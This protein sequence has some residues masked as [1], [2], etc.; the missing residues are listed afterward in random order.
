[1]IHYAPYNIIV[2]YEGVST[3][4][5]GKRLIVNRDGGPSLP[6]AQTYEERVRVI[7]NAIGRTKIGK[8]LLAS[9]YG[10]VPVYIIPYK[11]DTCNARTG[12]V[13]SNSMLGI[14]VQYS[15]EMW[16]VD[17]C[18]HYPGYR[19]VETLFHEMVHASRFTNYG[20]SG[21]NLDPLDRMQDHEEFLAVMITDMFRE[22]EGAHK[23]NRD[24]QT[25]EL[26]S[27]DAL[28]RFLS[29]NSHYLDAIEYFLG[30]VLVKRIVSLNTRFNPFRDFKRLKANHVD[31]SSKFF[32]PSPFRR[33]TPPP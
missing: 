4:L 27:Q 10:R 29:S 23:F 31:A 32:S 8:I 22:E 6:T 17:R 5:K 19:P 11:G 26:V 20:F 9:L 2:N 13:T 33:G 15:P 16:T 24:Y 21:L 18:G 28:E 7:L 3:D 14:G 25:G 1:M 12:Q 30:D